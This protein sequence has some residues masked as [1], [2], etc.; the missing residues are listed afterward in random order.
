M[1]AADSSADAYAP[2]ST[3]QINQ[4]NEFF[5][6]KFDPEM[7]RLPLTSALFLLLDILLVQ[8]A[9]ELSLSETRRQRLGV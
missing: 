1:S 5:W 3:S 6:W 9:M 4:E 2:V 7:R 8:V